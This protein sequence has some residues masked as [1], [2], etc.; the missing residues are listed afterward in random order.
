MEGGIENVTQPEPFAMDG[1]ITI[2][3]FR[4]YAPA[5]A[6]GSA[7]YPDR[8]FRDRLHRLEAR[9]TFGFSPGIRIDFAGP[10]ATT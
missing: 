5:L 6:L 1:L 3:G 9:R 4:C 7:D 8:I 10:F 2:E